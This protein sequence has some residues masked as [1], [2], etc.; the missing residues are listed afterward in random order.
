MKTEHIEVWTRTQ[1][2]R[3][4]W[5]KMY[6]S[7][8]NKCIIEYHCC[9]TVAEALRHVQLH[10]N[11]IKA[12]VNKDMITPG[13]LLSQSDLGTWKTWDYYDEGSASLSGR[14][15]VH[16]TVGI[17]YQNI[18]LQPQP[19]SHSQPL[20]IRVSLGKGLLEHWFLKKLVETKY[21]YRRLFFAVG[22]YVS[23][24]SYLCLIY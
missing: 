24:F 18:K 9:L 15:S 23:F 22:F 11:S 5:I 1:K 7:G 8:K 16:D 21:W 17:C 20:E 10:R 4:A 2:I 3:T 12:V 19:L 6:F 13:D 14:E